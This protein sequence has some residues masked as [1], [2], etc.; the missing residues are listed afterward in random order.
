VVHTSVVLPERCFDNYQ[1]SIRSQ[2]EKQIKEKTQM[3]ARFALLL[4]LLLPMAFSLPSSATDLT[5][6]FI[7]DIPAKVVEKE[8]GIIP[9]SQLSAEDSLAI[10]SYRFDGDTVKLLA[11][12]VEWTDR[13]GTYPRAV[14]DSF[15]FSVNVYPGGS[16]ADYY[17]EVSYGQLTVV[18]YLVDWYNAGLYSNFNW[19]DFEDILFA[20]DPLIDYSQFDANNDGDVDAV[21]FIR[22][23]NGEEDS[24][25][26]DDIWSFAISYGSGSGPGPFDGVYVSR[27]NTSPETRPLHDSDYPPGFLGVD[28]LNRI[29]VFAHELGHN[30]GLPDLYDYDDKLDT[31]TYTTPGDNNDHPLVDWDIMGY[32]GYGYLAIGSQIPSHFCG[33]SKRELG[34]IQPLVLTGTHADLVIY[35]I[36][37][38]NDSSLYKLELNETGSEYFLLEYRNTHSTGKFDKLDSDFSCYLWPNLS[39]GCD[40]LD[41]GLLITHVDDNVYPNDGTPWYLHYGVVVMDAGYNPAMDTSA[42]PEG[43]VTDSAQWWYPYETRKGAL[44]SNNVPGQ[45]L[46]GPTTYP[47]SDGYDGPSGIVVRVDSIVDDRL[48]AYVSDLG[49][50]DFDNDGIPDDSDNCPGVYN[51]DQLDVDADGVGD[52]CDNCPFAVNP[53]QEDSDGDLSGDSCDNCLSVANPG[54]ED[55]NGDGIGDACCCLVRGN[56]NGLSGVN[57]VDLT[58][59]V[60][61]LFRSGNFPPC[62]EEGNVDNVGE[63]NVADVTYLVD[64]LFRG[65]EPPPPCD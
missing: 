55:T 60:N 6:S 30:L 11:I 36:E 8:L 37:T 31:S 3:K 48:Y 62:P 1:H 18:G 56:V 20:L 17:H 57:V 63:I 19:W 33:W 45:N 54:Q 49:S 61:Y 15:L 32:Y 53:L 5:R 51:P 27:W 64:Y 12:L 29:R 23:G 65:G 42:N 38:H 24:Q 16:V 25:N 41:R 40:T 28:T 39:Y 22:S 43:H 34:W 58:Y 21:V 52:S 35:D 46:F 59:L 14:F 26:P 10:R 47:S 44:F 50:P 9:G 4:T 2:Y 7:Y 13:P